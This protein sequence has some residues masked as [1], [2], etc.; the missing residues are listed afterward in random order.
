MK[1]IFPLMLLALVAAA[2]SDSSGPGAQGDIEVRD[3]TF[4][5]SGFSTTAGST[6][7]W[8]W[9]GATPHNVTWVGA[10]APGPSPT[11]TTGTYQRTFDAAGTY[12]YYCTIHGTPTTGM[13][14]TVTVP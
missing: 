6:V 10:G 7:T 1:I 11:Q 5:P 13:R 14:G 4:S 8:D 9:T 3:N 12:D 2:C